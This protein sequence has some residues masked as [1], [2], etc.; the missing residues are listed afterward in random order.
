MAGFELGSSDIGGD[1]SADCAH[2]HCPGHAILT[3][4]IYLFQFNTTFG[5]AHLTTTTT[6]IIIMH[7]DV[8]VRK[9]FCVQSRLLL[10]GR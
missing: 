8:K 5:W 10:L 4:P 7:H 2:N 6:I 1:C 9:N 3:P